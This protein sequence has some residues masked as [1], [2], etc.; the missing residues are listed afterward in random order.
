VSYLK[1][2]FPLIRELGATGVLLEWEDMFPFNGPLSVIVAGNA[3]S[4]RDVEDILAAARGSQLE[5]IPLVQ[6]FGHVEFA[7]KHS[8]LSG[9]REVPESPQALCPSL[10]A[11][12]DFVE[13][14]IEQASWLLTS[15]AGSGLVSVQVCCWTPVYE[16]RFPL[17]ILRPSMLSHHHFH[18][19]VNQSFYRRMAFSGMLRRVALLRTD[20][21]EELSA[22]FIRMARI[23]ELGTTLAVNSNRRTLRRNTKYLDEGGAKFL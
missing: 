23:G 21:S 12:M 18:L 14:M 4:R 19:S 11:S 1:R 16:L 13:K 17:V 15:L 20:L 5:V 22:S 7:L 2:L 8:E 10:N 6:T 3:Y 9:L